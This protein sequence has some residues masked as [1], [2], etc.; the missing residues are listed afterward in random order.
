LRAA[1]KWCRENRPKSK[2]LD[3]GNVRA[4][5][6]LDRGIRQCFRRQPLDNGDVGTRGARDLNDASSGVLDL[7]DGSRARLR[8][9]YADEALDEVEHLSGSL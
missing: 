8:V 1:G 4:A 3:V 5:L 6:D 9:S 7:D 2:N